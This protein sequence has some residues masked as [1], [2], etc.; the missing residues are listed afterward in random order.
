ML[1]PNRKPR[2]KAAPTI[3]YNVSVCVCVVG[4]WVCSGCTD[5]SLGSSLSCSD[6][7]DY[8]C[9]QTNIALGYTSQ[10]T[11]HHKQSKVVGESPESVRQQHSHLHTGWSIRSWQGTH[12]CTMVSSNNGFLPYTSE[13][14]PS[15]GE[16]RNW[17]NEYREPRRPAHIG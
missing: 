5:H 1:G 13:E 7:S 14:A 6:I 17:R 12:N 11:G 3:A 9:A 15:R 2:E 8:S 4:G 16:V 10:D